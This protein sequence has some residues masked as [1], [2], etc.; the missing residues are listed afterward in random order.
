[1]YR[2]YTLS[3]READLKGE[4][5]ELR[6]AAP[7]SLSAVAEAMNYLRKERE[8]D[9]IKVHIVD[10]TRLGE[11]EIEKLV[12]RMKKTGKRTTVIWKKIERAKAAR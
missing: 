3:Y 2:L 5:G 11:K 6:I 8:L 7:S 10:S 9:G 4:K 1:M 12:E